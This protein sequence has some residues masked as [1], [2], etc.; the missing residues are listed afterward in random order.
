MGSCR[1]QTCSPD[2]ADISLSWH[3]PSRTDQQARQATASSATWETGSACPS[4]CLSQ[5]ISLPGEDDLGLPSFPD[6]T[7]LEGLGRA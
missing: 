7:D 3:T 1:V 5:K 2:H 4:D 6:L